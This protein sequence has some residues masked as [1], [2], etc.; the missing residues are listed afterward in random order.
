[1]GPLRFEWGYIVNPKPTDQPSK[2]EFSI[3]TTF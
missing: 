1:M 3:G 2:F